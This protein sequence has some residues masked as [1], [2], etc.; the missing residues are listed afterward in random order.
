MKEQSSRNCKFLDVAPNN[1]GRIVPLRTHTY[2][3]LAPDPQLPPM[4]D[5]ITR[6][7]GFKATF[8]R[9]Y[10][11]PDDGKECPCHEPRDNQ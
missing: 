7:Y 2:R 11:S 6:S 5:A 9:C 1:A 3:C 8:S 4:P 10:M